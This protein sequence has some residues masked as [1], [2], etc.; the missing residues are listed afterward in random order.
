ML[1]HKSSNN[2]LLIKGYFDVR[3]S[4]NNEYKFMDAWISTIYLETTFQAMGNR[5]Y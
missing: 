4:S 5:Y 3:K 1:W 2:K